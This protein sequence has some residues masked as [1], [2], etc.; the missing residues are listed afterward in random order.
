MAEHLLDALTSSQRQQCVRAHHAAGELSCSPHNAGRL[1]PGKDAGDG[2][3]SPCPRDAAPGAPR[4]PGG[5]HG[6]RP[7]PAPRLDVSLPLVGT[8]EDVAAAAS[9][10]PGPGGAAPGAAGTLPLGQGCPEPVTPVLSPWG[11]VPCAW[12]PT[13]GESPV[14]GYTSWEVTPLSS[15]RGTPQQRMGTKGHSWLDL[16]GAGAA[17]C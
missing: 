5:T 9:R 15:S 7:P 11:A 3:G 6:A 16:L 8:R 12:C 2:A 13:P 1:L 17:F 10:D 14:G 4:V